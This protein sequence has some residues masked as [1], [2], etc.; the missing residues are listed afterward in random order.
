L[1]DLERKKLQENKEI[2]RR[3]RLLRNRLRGV[4][5]SARNLLFSFLSDELTL[6]SA[7]P[8]QFGAVEDRPRIG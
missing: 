3:F 5:D 6:K 4:F 7:H 1:F 8:D 2:R